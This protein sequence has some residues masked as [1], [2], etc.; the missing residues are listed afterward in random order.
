MYRVLI[1]DDEQL[2]R[3]ALKIMISKVEGYTVIDAV[4]NGEEAI[5]ICKK[6]NVDIVFMDIMMPGISGIDASKTI[7]RNNPN[8][9]IFIISAYTDFEFAREALKVKVKEYMSKPVSFNKIKELLENYKENNQDYSNTLDSLIAL[10][11]HKDFREIYYNVP[12]VAQSIYDLNKDQKALDKTCQELYKGL[13]EYLDYMGEKKKGCHDFYSTLNINLLENN[14][15][16]FWLYNLLNYVAQE[17]SIKK[18]DLLE[19]VF[20]YID[21][22]IEEDIGL[23]E[24]VEKCSVSQGYLSRIF[25]KQLN[26]SVMEYIHMRKLILAKAYFSFTDLS[27]ADVGFQLGYNEGSYFSKVFKKYENMTAYQYKNKYGNK[28]S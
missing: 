27:I 16:V 1:V 8:T 5:E 26:V 24:I 10:L 17:V 9:T 2:M 12:D 3:E 22:H 6:N 11:K 23:N 15:L 7:Y 21:K 25:K 13:I 28:E 20:Q 4:S 19:T 14:G 18:Y